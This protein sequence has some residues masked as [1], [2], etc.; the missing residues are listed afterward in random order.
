MCDVPDDLRGWVCGAIRFHRPTHEQH[1]QHE[2]EDE[3]FLFGQRVHGETLVVT[4]SV[5]NCV[6]KDNTTALRR[7]DSTCRSLLDLSP[8]WRAE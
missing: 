6:S 3:L 2:A 7:P 4:E 1:P 5:R 8:R